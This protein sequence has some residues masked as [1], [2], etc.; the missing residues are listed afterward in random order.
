[1]TKTLQKK[2]DSV[3]EEIKVEEKE[4]PVEVKKEVMRLFSLPIDP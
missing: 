2:S 3:D 1:V 4:N